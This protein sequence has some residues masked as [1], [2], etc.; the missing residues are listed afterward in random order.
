M[1]KQN[2]H[3]PGG[4]VLEKDVIQATRLLKEAQTGLIEVADAMAGK[5]GDVDFNY[6]VQRRDKSSANLDIFRSPKWFDIVKFDLNVCFGIVFYLY[7]SGRKK[8]DLTILYLAYLLAEAVE[9]GREAGI[10]DSYHHHDPFHFSF[11][12]TE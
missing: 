5:I 2:D 10:I 6:A 1:H 8:F 3:W 11:L 7:K 9:K 4:G 12:L